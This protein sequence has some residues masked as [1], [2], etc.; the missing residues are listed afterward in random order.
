MYN[1]YSDYFLDHTVNVNSRAVGNFW[2]GVLRGARI[3]S[4]VLLFQ[5]GNVYVGDH[6]IVDSDILPDHKSATILR[7]DVRSRGGGGWRTYLLLSGNGNP[8]SVQV[9]CGGGLPAALHLSD[10]GGPGCR[11]RSGNQLSSSGLASA[12]NQSCRCWTTF[13]RS[14]YFFFHVTWTIFTKLKT[15]RGGF[16]SLGWIS[17]AS[18]NSE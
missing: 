1:T 17:K 12:R 15:F 18:F 9:K 5:T 13:P 10:S 4:T 2:N 16:R 11:V 7:S 3:F 6:I 14:N 8:S